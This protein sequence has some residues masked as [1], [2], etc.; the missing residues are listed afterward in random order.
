M[1]AETDKRKNK[2]LYLSECEHDS[3]GVGFIADIKG[4]KSR[5]TVADALKI[6][7]CMDHRGASGADEN[8]GDG[9]GILTQLPHDFFRPECEKLHIDLPAAGDCERGQSLVVWAFRDGRE[10]AQGV[11]RFLNKN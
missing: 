5:Q 8:T 9:A 7:V 1:K 11:H 6:L 2:G 3:C 10:A 4:K